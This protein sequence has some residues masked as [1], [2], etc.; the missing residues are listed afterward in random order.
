MGYCYSISNPPCERIIACEL[1][2]DFN[3]AEVASLINDPYQILKPVQLEV[4]D[5][6]T[7]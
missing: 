4:R 3:E 5:E 6:H 1:E 7:A 2:G